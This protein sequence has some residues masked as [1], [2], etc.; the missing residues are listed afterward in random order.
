MEA[1][2]AVRRKLP[3]IMERYVRNVELPPASVSGATIPATRLA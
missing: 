1:V 2:D 3:H